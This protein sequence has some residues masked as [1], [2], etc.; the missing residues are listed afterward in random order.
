MNYRKLQGGRAST[1]WANKKQEAACIENITNI[2]SVFDASA[3][4]EYGNFLNDCLQKGLHL[5]QLIPI[6]LLRYRLGIVGITA[7]SCFINNYFIK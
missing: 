3:K 2:R 7:G 1:C 4:D 5:I 6:L